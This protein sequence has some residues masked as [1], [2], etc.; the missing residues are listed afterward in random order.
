MTLTHSHEYDDEPIDG[1]VE[2]SPYMCRACE[3]ETG[4]PYAWTGRTWA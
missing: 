4:N 3:A 1:H 2:L